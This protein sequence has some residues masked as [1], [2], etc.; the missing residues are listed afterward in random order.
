LQAVNN[1]ADGSLRLA[2]RVKIDK[3]KYYN[4]SQRLYFQLIKKFLSIFMQNSGNN[5]IQEVTPGPQR[6]KL[7]KLAVSGQALFAG[8]FS[9]LTFGLVFLTIFVSIKKKGVT[10]KRLSRPNIR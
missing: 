7:G 4:S 6:R 1:A 8:G 3:K 10:C 9:R 2:L 5:S